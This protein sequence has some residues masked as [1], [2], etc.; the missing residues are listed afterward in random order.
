[1]G[2]GN[3]IKKLRES[4]G[5]TQKQLAYKIGVSAV[6][7]TRYENNDREPNIKILN[8]LSTVFNI[9]IDSLINEDQ[10]LIKIIIDKILSKNN[11][12][13]LSIKSNIPLKDLKNILNLKNNLNL[14]YFQNLSKYL[15]LTQEEEAYLYSNYICNDSDKE[16]KPIEFYYYLLNEYGCQCTY[17][18]KAYEDA[19]FNLKQKFK[20]TN[21]TNKTLINDDI[22][23]EYINN[24][25]TYQKIISKLSDYIYIK[26]FDYKKL[27]NRHYFYIFHK[28]CDSLEFELYKL[29]KNNYKISK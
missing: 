7:I 8:K 10:S 3:Q 2:I 26:K 11:I 27:N 29:K 5:L 12:E 9:S 14:N 18:S 13:D 15:K 16:F 21:Y 22:V 6:T 28:L 1:M 4:K 25:E 23:T 19:E 24:I 17:P 20:I